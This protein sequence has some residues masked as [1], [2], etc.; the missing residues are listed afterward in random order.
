M[1]F[2]LNM[3][4][5]VNYASC[6]LQFFDVLDIFLFKIFHSQC[7]ADIYDYLKKKA[8]INYIFAFSFLSLLNS[9]QKQV[10]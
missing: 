6:S 1:S 9:R 2:Y 5:E 8:K 3:S 10:V 7:D 4:L